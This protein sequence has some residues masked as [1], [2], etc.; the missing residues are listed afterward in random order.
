M[1]ERPAMTD[2]V[3]LTEAIAGV[4]A[5]HVTDTFALASK[6]SCGK[7]WADSQ[8]ATDYPDQHRAHLAQQIAARLAAAPAADDGL[9]TGVAALADEW[10]L[11]QFPDEPTATTMRM[12]LRALLAPKGRQR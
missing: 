3:A 9:A 10:A 7:W 1:V 4:L 11:T 2:P 6:C 12:D 5:E 8:D